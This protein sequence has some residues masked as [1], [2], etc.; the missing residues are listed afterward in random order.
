MVL[1]ACGE[2]PISAAIGRAAAGEASR[3]D[4]KVR[5]A[6]DRYLTIDFILAPIF[7]EQGQVASRAVG[8]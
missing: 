2:N 4:V 3:Y 8:Y 7:D 1:F 5:M 6:E